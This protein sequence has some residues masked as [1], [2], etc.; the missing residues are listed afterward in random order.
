MVEKVV[1]HHRPRQLLR[2]S[3]VKLAS[4]RGRQSA[5]ILI[6]TTRLPLTSGRALGSDNVYIIVFT[7]VRL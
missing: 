6:E 2:E 3:T 1:T 5:V 7:V 4:E